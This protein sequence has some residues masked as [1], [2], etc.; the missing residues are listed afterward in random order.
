MQDFGDDLMHMD[1]EKAVKDIINFTDEV[2]SDLSN[3]EETVP[4]MESSLKDFKQWAKRFEHPISLAETA[5]K[6]Y[7]MHRK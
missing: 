7:L 5:A 3:C 4:E 2:G 1:L 6:N